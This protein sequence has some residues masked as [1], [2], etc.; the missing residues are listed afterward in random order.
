MS[1]GPGEAL[2]GFIEA[3]GDD[4]P[5][6]LYD[7]APCGYLTTDADGLILKT[8]Q[9][10]LTLSGY[11]REELVGQRR[12]AQLLSR[13]GQIFHETHY[14]PL[15]RMHG[16]AR[17]IA[18]DLVRKDGSRLPTLVN[19]VLE[20]DEQAQ[21]TVIR[22]AVFAAEHRR[23]YEE[24][25]LHA[26]QRA[27]ESQ[28]RAVSLART[29][30]ATL[31]PPTSPRI[32]HVDVAAAYR[33]AGDG[34]QVGGDFYDVF[35]V[36]EDEWV[37]L[38]G[39]VCGKGV[40]AAVVTALARYT[41]RAAAV[42]HARPSDALAMLNQ[43][44]LGHETDRFCTVAFLRVRRGDDGI[45]CR[46]ASGGHP[47]P[48]LCRENG[49]VVEV[50]RPGSLVGIL[51][52]TQFEDVEVVMGPGETLLLYTDGVVEARSNGDQYGTERLAQ[53]LRLGHPT[54]DDLVGA[55]V[56]DVLA[57]QGGAAA[58]DIAVLALRVPA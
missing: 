25:L 58:D 36:D 19:A 56:E 39:D 7:N 20:R 6:H 37:V 2:E 41:L 24:E 26:K 15:L 1:V 40:E 48:L 8:N 14:A 31:I 55:V 50:G 30:Q 4:D 11:S 21:P 38:L 28:A 33:P 35:K 54:A 27:E 18:L 22:T 34:T 53:I 5:Q 3:L 12:F 13:G 57:H 10:F 52:D 17:E 29:L 23:Q 44:M 42:E 32:P 43:V 9:T 45:R 46:L 51:E 47:L 49:Q 16:A